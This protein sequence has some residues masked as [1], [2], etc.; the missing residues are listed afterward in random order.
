[1]KEKNKNVPYYWISETPTP[2]YRFKVYYY[3]PDKAADGSRNCWGTHIVKFYCR[4]HG[5]AIKFIKKQG[6]TEKNQKFNCWHKKGEEKIW[7]RRKDERRK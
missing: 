6:Y 4:T 3:S 7:E 2:N 1:M 5:E